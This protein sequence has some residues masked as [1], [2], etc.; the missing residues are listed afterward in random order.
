M[1]YSEL[2]AKAAALR[3]E[4]RSDDEIAEM[5]HDDIAQAAQH[6][7]QHPED[8]VE[9]VRE[10]VNNGGDVMVK[11]LFHILGTQLFNR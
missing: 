11:M 5:L 7:T 3:E 10:L 9:P 6:A 8:M 2:R 4:G 1:D